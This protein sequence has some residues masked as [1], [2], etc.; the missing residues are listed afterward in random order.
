MLKVTKINI[1][2]YDAVDDHGDDAHQLTIKMMMTMMLTMMTMMMMMT[3]GM[4]MIM[5]MV[6]MAMTVLLI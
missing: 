2:F 1:R 3:T 6:M 5:T 4:M